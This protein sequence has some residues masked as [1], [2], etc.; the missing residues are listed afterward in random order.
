MAPISYMDEP[1]YQKSHERRRLEGMQRRY[2]YHIQ[3][4]KKS[5]LVGWICSTAKLQSK[6]NIMITGKHIQM[7]ENNKNCKKKDGIHI[8]EN[9]QNI[10]KISRLEQVLKTATAEKNRLAVLAIVGSTS[11]QMGLQEPVPSSVDT[12]PSWRTAS[13]VRVGYVHIGL[14]TTSRSSN[15]KFILLVILVDDDPL[16]GRLPTTKVGLEALVGSEAFL[17]LLVRVAAAEDLDN[18]AGDETFVVF[19]LFS[20]EFLAGGGAFEGGLEQD[21]LAIEDI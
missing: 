19:F 17:L 14:L 7:K 12:I 1:K 21:T 18:D 4:E 13:T 10:S 9:N 2:S 5:S 8:V 15:L 16:L 3:K 20:G 6:C 11:V